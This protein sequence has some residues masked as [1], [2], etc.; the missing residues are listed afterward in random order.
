MALARLNVPGADALRRLDRAGAVGRATTVTIQ[1]VFEAVGAHAAGEHERRGLCASS[2]TSR[3]PAPA[4]AAASSPP[5]RWRSPASF[6][7]SR[8]SAAAA[9]RPTTRSKAE[10]ARGSRRARHATGRAGRQ[11]R[12]TSSRA[13]AIENAIASVAT[14]GGSTNAV[15]HLI[16]IARE[17]GVEL[18][19]ADF[20]RDQRAR[21]PLLADLKPSGRFVAT[22]L[23][24]AGGSALVAKRLLEVGALAR[25]RAD[26]H[27]ADRSARKRRRAVETPGQEVVRPADR[28]AQAE[29]RPGHPARQ[30]GARRRGDEGLRRRPLAASRAG[31]GLRQ[32][33]GGVRR[34]PAPGHQAR[35]RRRHPLRRAERRTGH[36][37]DARRSPRAIVGAGLGDSVALVTDGR[38]SGATRGFMRRPHRPGSVAWRPAGGRPRRRHHRASTSAEPQSST[39]RLGS[40]DLTRADG[41]LAA[42]APR[43]TSGVL[44]KYARL[45]S[46]ASSGQPVSERARE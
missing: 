45:V 16:A 24:A 6:S 40:D 35:R 19:L 31:A 44:A 17:A 25:R 27:R 32:R 1:D 33:G 4:P 3:C 7:A 11:A 46:S 43:Y 14:T 15:L 41:A 20:D 10:V 36:A 26:R 39:S 22:D 28:A 38:F 2:R 9:C 29:R 18:E 5:T 13:T 37:R 23:H 12:A 8:R 30:P 42:P 21:T 34:R